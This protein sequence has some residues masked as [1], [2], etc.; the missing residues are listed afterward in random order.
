MTPPGGGRPC[1]DRG[2]G[3]S[4]NNA[5]KGYRSELELVSFYANGPDPLLSGRHGGQ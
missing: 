5:K 4:F 3:V 1:P 2:I